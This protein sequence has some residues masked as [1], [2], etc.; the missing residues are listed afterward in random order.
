MHACAVFGDLTI[1][2]R[3]QAIVLVKT[4]TQG[5]WAVEA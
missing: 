2:V 4:I 5:K 1:T 3:G